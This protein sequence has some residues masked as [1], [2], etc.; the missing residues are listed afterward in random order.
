MAKIIH[1][2]DEPVNSSEHGIIFDT[3]VWLTINGVQRSRNDDGYSA[4]YKYILQHQMPIYTNSH[5]VSEYINVILRNDFSAWKKETGYSDA[6]YKRDYRT[7]ANQRYVDRFNFAVLS[8]KEDLLAVSK[9]I[10]VSD[11][12]I[13]E[14]T[15]RKMNN[16]LDFNDELILKSAVNQGLPILTNDRDYQKYDGNVKIYTML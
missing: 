16:S 3:N 4:V 10:S 6:D 13:K 9:V 14:V 15:D 7:G 1:L 8:A 12:L 2:K 11:T 5:I